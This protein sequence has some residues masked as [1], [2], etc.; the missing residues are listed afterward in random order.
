MAFAT[1]A[2]LEARLGVSYDDGTETAQAQALLDDATAY[3]Q[4]ELGQLIEAGTATYTTRWLGQGPIRLPQAPVTDVTTVLVD[5]VATTDFDF[6]DQ[7]LHL[8][9]WWG[10]E[11]RF[12]G[13]WLRSYLDVTVTFDYGYDTVPAE[14]KA[15]TCVLASQILSGAGGG[16]LGIPSARSETIDDYSV[17][18]VADGSTMTLPPQVLE[19][20]RSRYGA[21]AYITGVGRS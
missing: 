4:A 15:W 1:T 21:G 8:I 6:V 17:T 14:L 13:T 16:S 19:R 5:G 3:L 10:T 9:G 11:K 2:D 12:N 20:L 7:E 18:Y